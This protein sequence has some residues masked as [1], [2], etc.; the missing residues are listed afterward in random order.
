MHLQ[1]DNH[2][3]RKLSVLGFGALGIQLIEQMK[4]DYLDIKQSLNYLALSDSSTLLN[5]ST[6]DHQI[7]L[8]DIP[9]EQQRIDKP[10]SW[11]SQSTTAKLDHYLE[12]SVFSLIILDANEKSLYNDYANAI[13]DFS[14]SKSLITFVALFGDPEEIG[15]KIKQLQTQADLV[16]EMPKLNIK[17]WFSTINFQVAYHKLDTL[18]QICTKFVPATI[19]YDLADLRSLIETEHKSEVLLES[20]EGSVQDDAFF[21]KMMNEFSRDKFP[22]SARFNKIFFHCVGGTEM[23]VSWLSD[24][25]LS[26]QSH[27]EANDVLCAIVDGEDFFPHQIKIS[28]L[29]VV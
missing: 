27:C 21:E 28:V 29:A 3:I 7:F 24:L 26:V 6:V 11:L 15:Q 25:L 8:E 22:L 18:I 4:S 13:A 2:R 14:K 23:R 20:I 9:I 1:F 16:L 17:P 10:K 5:A 12:G 19:P